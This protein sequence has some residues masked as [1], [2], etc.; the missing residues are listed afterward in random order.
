MNFRIY[1]RRSERRASM[2][3]YPTIK[4]DP[5]DQ[6]NKDRMRSEILM[7]MVVIQLEKT[8]WLEGLIAE[9]KDK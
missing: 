6:D 1:H 4:S 8:V 2:K 3:G 7:T 5:N 9:M